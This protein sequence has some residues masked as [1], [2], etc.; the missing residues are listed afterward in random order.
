[1][2]LNLFERMFITSPVRP[3]LQKHLEAKQLLKMGGPAP[4][5]VAL[6]IGCGPG[7]G[8]GLI[9]H[10]CLHIGFFVIP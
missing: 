5:A 4:G 9:V 8:I 2:K 1:M 10:P 7:S 6:E 3:F